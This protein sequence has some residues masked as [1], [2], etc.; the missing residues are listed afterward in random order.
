VLN[1]AN[2]S[3]S[4]P[5]PSF[6]IE[7]PPLVEEACDGCMVLVRLNGTNNKLQVRGAPEQE[8]VQSD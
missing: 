6:L 3:F 2:N 8:Q 5:F 7:Q 1:L 4:G